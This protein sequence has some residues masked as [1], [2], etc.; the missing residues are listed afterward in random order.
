MNNY[1]KI[2][3]ITLT[4]GHENYIIN[5][6]EGILMQD[7]P[8]E[9]EFI[10]SNDCSPDNT[11]QIIHDYLSK[12]YIPKNFIIKYVNHEIN[13]GIIPN[14]SWTLG[15]TTGKYIAICEGDDYW[16]DSSK[17]RRQVDFMEVN[18]DCSM[19]YH[20]YIQKF[21][22][23]NRPQ[24][25]IEYPTSVTVKLSIEEMIRNQF[26]RLVTILYRGDVV[27]LSP[28]WLSQA[29]L[30]DLALQLHL[31]SKGKVGYLA[32]N[33]MA[34]YNRGNP[35]SWSEGEFG[36][37]SQHTIWKIKRLEDQ[38]KTFQL[39]NENT[40]FKYQSYTQKYTDHLAY[41]FL[42]YYQDGHSK[43]EV[44]KRF[45]KYIKKPLRVNG[46]M[47]AFWLRFLLGKKY[48]NKIMK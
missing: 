18:L 16:T 25:I 8:G 43:K 28:S 39:F 13:K 1:P 37:E 14:F 47:K 20:A 2:S 3:V 31:F 6:L 32:G 9:I 45:K 36:N 4:Y 38:L 19:C 34:V 23:N 7:Y 29:P 5:T 22:N 40:D 46:Y 11:D 30:G 41:R 42:F 12:K 48:Y 24:K 21:I 26:V 44:Y 17:L 35:Q 15:E 10:I 33:P 27:D